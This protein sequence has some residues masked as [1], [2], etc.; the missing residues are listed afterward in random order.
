MA[1]TVRHS[2][3]CLKSESSHKAKSTLNVSLW[4]TWIRSGRGDCF[5]HG[6]CHEQSPKQS[7]VMPMQVRFP[8]QQKK[9]SAAPMVGKKSKQTGSIELEAV[10]VNMSV[11]WWRREELGLVRRMLRT[12]SLYRPSAL[13]RCVMSPLCDKLQR[14]DAGDVQKQWIKQWNET[15]TINAQCTGPQ[16]VQQ[17]LH[18]C[19]CYYD[20]VR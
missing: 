8:T 15:H 14:W 13:R 5:C 12:K 16:L 2:R 11:R 6:S 20:C 7:A 19:P 1:V 9:L 3:A 10:K 4:F 18:P 17:N